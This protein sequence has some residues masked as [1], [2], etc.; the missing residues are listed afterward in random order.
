M[1]TILRRGISNKS[2]KGMC[3]NRPRQRLASRKGGVGIRTMLYT[4]YTAQ[5]MHVVIFD[6]SEAQ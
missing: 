4:R 1:W 2:D 6:I 5:I 3:V